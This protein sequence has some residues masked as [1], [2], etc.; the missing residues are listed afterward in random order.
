VGEGDHVHIPDADGRQAQTEPDGLIG[1]AL[2]VPIAVEPLLLG[3]RDQA[4]VLQQA[5]GGVMAEA[6][7]PKDAHLI[8]PSAGHAPRVQAVCPDQ[9]V[10]GPGAPSQTAGGG[11]GRD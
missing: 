10:N 8:A 9:R 2:G 4:P 6:V 11:A 1:E 3:Q 5:G 7:D